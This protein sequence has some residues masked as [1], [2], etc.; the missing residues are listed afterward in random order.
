MATLFKP[1]KQAFLLLRPRQKLGFLII[2]GL[3]VAVHLLD[4][5]GLA[6]VGFLGATL[7][8]G[9]SSQVDTAFLGFSLPDIESA[10]FMWLLGA[11]VGFFLA[12][13]IVGTV[14]LRVTTMFL[15]RVEASSSA[16][17]ANFLF[18]GDIARMRS[19]SVGEI[20]WAVN[21]SSQLAFSTMLF[22]GSAI[23][24]ES[25]L[26]LTVF[27]VFVLVDSPTALLVTIYFVVLLVLFQ[28]SIDRR[29]RRLGVRMAENS[30][31]VNNSVLDLTRAF[32][33]ITVAEKRPY[34]L[35]R[36]AAARRKLALDWSLQ[37]F[38]QGLPRFFVE[39]ALMIGI[40]GIVLWQFASGDLS[41]GLVIAGVFLAGGTR[42]MA[43]ML[44]LQNAITDIRIQGPQATRAI[45][46]ISEARSR[47]ELAQ[48][49]ELATPPKPADY[50]T[51][52]AISVIIENL[53]FRYPDSEL[54]AVEDVDLMIEA[55]SFAALI[56][57]SGAGKTT[58]ADAVLGL[59]TP[60]RGSVLL[61]GRPPQ[62][63]RKYSPGLVAYVPQRPGMVSGTVAEN[64]ALGLRQDEVDWSRMDQVIH[65]SG[66]TEVVRA[67]PGGLKT[68]LGEHADSL[69]GGQLQRLGIA[70]ALYP[71]PRLLVL[72]EA[73]SALDA[74]TES[75][76]TE[77]IYN[78][79]GEVTL[80]VIAHRLSTVQHADKVF[81]LE[82]GK[83]SAEGTF[84]QVRQQVPLIER[85][86]QLL[87]ITE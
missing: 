2:V 72:D 51:T 56:G 4:V 52:R 26:F 84:Q 31:R 9:L 53:T 19:M 33:E 16:E 54:P 68:E 59:Q 47:S 70:R 69:S 12:K 50:P 34:F 48:R 83:I 58:L 86:V 60:S 65:E 30:V 20:Q 80:L 42:M 3:R 38:V 61:N 23:I 22:A 32:R 11:V 6:A 7:A 64:V 21:T 14:L 73:T 44:P 45:S 13:S 76:I 74:E 85:Y 37:R 8:A 24:T 27:A 46:L 67:L 71:C 39:A 10:N 79:R 49:D 29:L 55:G 66:L 41:N 15:A 18:S 57:P 35:A 63:L 75:S 1:I 40:M 36:F 77:T 17:V 78:L 62:E 5:L 82:V 28:L 43:A 25:A 81:V 87:K